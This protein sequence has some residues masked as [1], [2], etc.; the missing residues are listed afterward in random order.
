MADNLSSFKAGGIITK[1]EGCGVQYPFGQ[2][3][4]RVKSVSEDE[5][6]LEI[7]EPQEA[8]VG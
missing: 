8:K 2:F 6:E 5:M 1:I 4:Y 7:V 3:T